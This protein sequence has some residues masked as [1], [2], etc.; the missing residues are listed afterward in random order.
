MTN[1]WSRDPLWTIAVVACVGAGVVCAAHLAYSGLWID[2]IYTLHAIALPWKEMIIERLSRG[3]FPLYFTLMKVWMGLW[4]T[5]SEVVLRLPSLFFWLV[6]ICTFALVLRNEASPRAAPFVL[7]FLALNGLGL[8]QASEAR[9][10]TLALFLAV[11]YTA[12]YLHVARHDR[13]RI[14]RVGLILI[15]VFGFWATSTFVLTVASFLFDAIRRRNRLLLWLISLSLVLTS[16]TAVAPLFVHAATRERSEI[17]HVPPSVLL[18]HLVTFL[19][20]IL[21]WED[22]YTIYSPLVVLQ[23]I[24]AVEAVILL[25]YALRRWDDLPEPAKTGFGVTMFPLAIMVATWALAKG[26]GIGTALHGPA[27]Y[28]IGSLPAAAIFSGSVLNMACKTHKQRLVVFLGVTSILLLNAFTVAR[29]SLESPR[30]LLV[31]YFAPCWRSSDAVVVVPE[32]AREAVKMYVPQVKIDETLPRNLSE[33]DVRA[34]LAQFIGRSRLWLIW[35]HG[36]SSCAVA[37][38]DQLFGRGLS[39]SPHRYLGERRV[40]LYEASQEPAE[41]VHGNRNG[42]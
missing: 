38:A 7:V 14:T 42:Q 33:A 30:E 16:L 17:A 27:R 11:C 9:M 1:S 5:P 41:Q 32:Q 34:R 23:I 10:Y 2:E 36:K 31:R 39:S 22:Y 28:L 25:A 35:I 15:P 18:L 13:S 6:S 21:G 37:V 12:S 40:F 24:G 19:T 26:L 29:V 3:H 8:R 4:P 20:G